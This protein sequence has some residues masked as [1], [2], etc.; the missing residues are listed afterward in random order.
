MQI[1]EYVD[2]QVSVESS[3]LKQL[4]AGQANDTEVF[5]SILE[6]AA[7]VIEPNKRIS[8]IFPDT[9]KITAVKKV[10]NN[11]V[12]HASLLKLDEHSLDLEVDRYSD[13]VPGEIDITLQLSV[14]AD[15]LG[16]VTV[17]VMGAGL[18]S[19]GIVAVVLS[20]AMVTPANTPLILGQNNQHLSDLTLTEPMPKSLKEGNLVIT[21]PDGII[22]AT[23]LEVRL[24]SGDLEL[25][26]ESIDQNILTI[27]VK[28]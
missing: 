19:S 17:E 3:N 26:S 2:S 28:K 4:L 11:P 16:V 7:G 24:I 22:W 21:L 6:S 23:K 8:V 20:P 15:Y 12:F 5:F 13:Q 18:E 10:S 27:K 14:Q 9:V 1:A 25:A